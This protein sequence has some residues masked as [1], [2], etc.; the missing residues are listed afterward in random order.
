MVS[1][2]FRNVKAIE[3]Q[4]PNAGSGETQARDL[5]LEVAINNS[6]DI[7]FDGK[8]IELKQLKNAIKG[9]KTKRAIINADSES[10]HGKV[11]EVLDAF[12][13]EGVIDVALSVKGSSK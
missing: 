4:L 9:T 13:E 5:A 7:Y 1:S 2:Q 11:I 12:R 8:K 10:A 6:G 3:V